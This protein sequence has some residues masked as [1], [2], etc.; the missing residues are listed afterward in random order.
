MNVNCASAISRLEQTALIRVKLQRMNLCSLSSEVILYNDIY[1]WPQI[2]T[3]VSCESDLVKYS[4]DR[5]RQHVESTL[6]ASAMAR[7]MCHLNL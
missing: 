4:H 6:L 2:M 5:G 3:P 7:E 1:T